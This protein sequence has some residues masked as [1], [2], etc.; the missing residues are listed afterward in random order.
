M[1]RLISLPVGI[2]RSS[3]RLSEP[4]SRAVVPSHCL[5]ENNLSRSILKAAIL[6]LSDLSSFWEKAQ[7]SDGIQYEELNP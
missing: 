5:P 3:S 6:H 4:R 7:S 1:W 2:Q